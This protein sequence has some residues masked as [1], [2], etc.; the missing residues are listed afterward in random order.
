MQPVQC[1]GRLKGHH[2][3]FLPCPWDNGS[4][5]SAKPAGI[6][7]NSRPGRKDEKMKRKKKEPK[8]KPKYG[9]LSCVA[10]LYKLMWK[11]ERNLAFV[12]AGKIP[13]DLAAAALALYTPVLILRALE[14][15][16]GFSPV[17]IVSVGLVLAGTL[18]SL[19]RQLISQKGEYMELY[20]C[21]RMGVLLECRRLDRDFELDYDVEMKKLDERADGAAMNNHTRAVH[22]P[23][24]FSLVVV[25][26][27]K[28]LLFGTVLTTLSPWVILLIAVCSAVNMPL[29]AWERKRNYETQ[30]N[31]NALLKKISYLAF[32]VGRDFRYGK[33]VRIYNLRGYLSLLA[34]K[35]TNDYAREK[36]AVERRVSVVQIADFLVVLLRDGIMYAW[37]ISRAVAGEIDASR[38]V[39]YF[40]AMTEL[41]E[42]MTGIRWWWSCVCEG[43]MQVS[44]FRECLEF[45]DRMNRGEGIPLPSGAFSITFR[46]VS[47]RY[48]EGEKDVLEHVSFE[49]RAGEKLALVGLNGAGKTTL[50]RLMCGLLTPT[51]GEILIDGH[52]PREYNREELYSLFGLVPQDYHLLPFSIA[53]NVACVEEESEIDRSKLQSCLRQ[54]GL[55]EKVGS[56]PL[57]A[58]TPLNRQINPGG[59]EFSGGETQKLLLARL[60]YRKPKCIILD[61][62]TAALDPIAEDR[63]YRQYNEITDGA[64]SVF[65]SHRLASTRFC[66]RIFLLDG[67]R[68]AE[69]GSHEELMA[70]GKKYREL[71]EVQ[72]KYY[73]TGQEES[74]AG[75]RR[76]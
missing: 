14:E 74:L 33:D 41:A 52:S 9:M 23:M 12:A 17:A 54:A 73:K 31:R 50:I 7:E 29:S 43:A 5:F 11:Y 28:F 63:M 42:V 8:R 49:L 32:K 51:E 62:P 60:L 39:L 44:D 47:Y 30:D 4:V 15:S 35:L 58:D 45:P 68:I 67:A 76:E 2:I 72:S 19:L 48:P 20:L 53:R 22:F 6:Y 61:E 64:T 18:S 34:K 27:L 16:G 59:V 56:L 40:T 70:A 25:I 69:T 13:V 37:L 3:M 71:F 38:F 26:V 55:E 65:I 36:K 21:S 66:D 57:G 1:R 24:E 75:E 46:D 10:Y